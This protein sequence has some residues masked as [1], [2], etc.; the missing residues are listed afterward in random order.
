VRQL[1]YA[2]S[3]GEGNDRRLAL[4]HVADKRLY[5]G[6]LAGSGQRLRSVS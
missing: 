2:V 5:E 6:K 3:P 4:F 1:R